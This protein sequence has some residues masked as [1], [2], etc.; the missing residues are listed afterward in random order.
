M[1]LFYKEGISLLPPDLFNVIDNQFSRYDFGL[2]LL[3]VG[4]DSSGAHIH[5]IRNPGLDDCFDSLGFHA[6]G[7]GALHAIQHFIASRYKTSYNLDEAI[8]VVY[9]AKKASEVAP[10]V[11]RET[12]ICLIMRDRIIQVDPE[13][14]GELSKIYEKVRKPI[15]EEIRESSKLLGTLLEARKTE[16]ENE[17]KGGKENNGTNEK[18]ART[19]S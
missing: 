17:K 18:G 9:A 11:G 19:K 5:T 8:S 12:N 10:G 3:V 7:V 2:E 4:I 16:A 15:I 1:E 6:I 14:I 13:I